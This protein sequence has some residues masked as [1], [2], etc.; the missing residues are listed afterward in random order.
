MSAVKEKK[1]TGT[2][3]KQ[4]TNPYISIILPTHERYP[5]FNE[6]TQLLN[7]LLKKVEN[8]LRLKYPETIALQM[9]NKTSE[10]INN[11]E[12]YFHPRSKGLGIFV[13]PFSEKVIHFPF[14]VTEKIVVSDHFE[15]RAIILAESYQLDYCVLTLNEKSVRLFKCKGM[16]MN[17]V[18][19]NNFPAQFIDEFE[20]PKPSRGDSWDHSLKGMDD[21]STIMEER[22][23]A[24]LRTVDRKISS[25]MGAETKLIL[26][27]GKKNIADFEKISRHSNKI[28][29]IVPGNYDYNEQKTFS[30]LVWTQVMNYLKEENEKIFTQFVE[31][32]GTG[33]AVYGIENV[34]EA[35][36]EGKGLA[37]LV[38]KDFSQPAFLGNNKFKLFLHPPVTEHKIVTDSVNDLIEI[39]LEKGGKVV[40]MENG[41]L[42]DFRNIGLLL[43]YT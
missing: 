18:K 7:S 28:I 5:H 20:E 17:E 26:S 16:E 22:V 37:L 21:K 39:V 40:F 33:L 34:W 32:T 36:Q 38:E 27:G 13:S 24:F 35:A 23:E 8:S 43:R 14:P 41:D 15:N 29:A 2:I 30:D 19:N 9:I 1:E 25:Y 42:K 3:A 11:I 31:A 12:F 10:V 4:D 6:D